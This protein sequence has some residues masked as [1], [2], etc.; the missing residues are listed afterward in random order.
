M[1]S[2]VL[3]GF[4]HDFCMELLHAGLSQMRQS[5][6]TVG[7]WCAFTGN[8]VTAMSI[9]VF[10]IFIYLNIFI[11]GLNPQGEGGFYLSND[12]Q[13][14]NNVAFH[15]RPIPSSSAVL[16]ELSVGMYSK[17]KFDMSH[18]VRNDKKEDSNGKFSKP[19]MLPFILS[20]SHNSMLIVLR[21]LP[22]NT[23]TKPPRSVLA[24]TSP[25][26]GLRGRGTLLLSKVSQR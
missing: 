21:F 1:W 16:W 4:C 11:R 12:M 15:L 26:L 23:E 20:D 14:R 25:G 7:L 13:M 10:M 17:R 22:G 19:K 2:C 18:S 24:S 8:V 9:N 5:R 3:C 6:F